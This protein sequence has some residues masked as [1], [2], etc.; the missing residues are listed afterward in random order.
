MNIYRWIVNYDINI[1]NK[2]F[3]GK[4]I[5]FH[6]SKWITIAITDSA[7]NNELIIC[8]ALAFCMIESLIME[9]LSNKNILGITTPICLMTP[10]VSVCSFVHV[11]D[12]NSWPLCVPKD[13]N[14]VRHWLPVVAQLVIWHIH[15]RTQWLSDFETVK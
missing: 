7:A 5:K 3:Y 12:L 10:H 13:K 2:L 9:R 6:L 11:F 8:F 1:A 15:Y 14:M 4:S